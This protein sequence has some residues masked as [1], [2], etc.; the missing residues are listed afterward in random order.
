MCEIRKFDRIESGGGLTRWVKWWGHT[1]EY[2]DGGDV[3]SPPD[4]KVARS[5]GSA[6]ASNERAWHLSGI[7]RGIR[8][9][10]QQPRVLL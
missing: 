10:C 2:T 8:E 3:S 7:L 4:G 6:R 5:I 9:S 1:L